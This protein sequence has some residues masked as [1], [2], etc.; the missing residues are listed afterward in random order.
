MQSAGGSGGY[1]LQIRI[2]NCLVIADLKVCALNAPQSSAWLGFL[3]FWFISDGFSHKILHKTSAASI[4]YE[5]ASFISCNHDAS[6]P[7]VATTQ[8]E[9][10]N[11]V[12]LV[13]LSAKATRN[14]LAY[15]TALCKTVFICFLKWCWSDC[16]ASVFVAA[17]SAYTSHEV[18]PLALKS[19]SPYEILKYAICHNESWSVW[20]GC[21]EC[22]KSRLQSTTD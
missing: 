22:N 6:L 3:L 4:K 19:S 9:A 17:N 18:F 20:L 10:L 5:T 21:R 13:S 7:L 2:C 16:L 11:L 8:Q 15:T 1:Y 12:M 14:F